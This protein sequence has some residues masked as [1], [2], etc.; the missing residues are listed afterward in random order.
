MFYGGDL[1]AKD[2]KK[3]ERKIADGGDAISFFYLPIPTS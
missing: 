3:R 2:A 1:T